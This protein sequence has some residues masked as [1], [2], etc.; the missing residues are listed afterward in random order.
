MADDEVTPLTTTTTNYGWVKPD[1][2]ASD[3]AWGGLL[4]T[5][6]DGIDSTV[7]S[8]S[9]VANAAYPASNP[10][11]YQT[12]AQVTAAVPVASSTTPLVNGTAAVGT[13]TTWARADHVHPTDTS[14]WLGDNRIINGDMR[15][16]QRNNGASGTAN[17]VYTA[18]RWFYSSNV[19]SKGTWTRT[20]AVSTSAIAQAGFPYYLN[21]VSS[22]AYTAATTE[23]FAFH[24]RIEADM[25][26]DFAW[27]TANAQPVTL[28]FW[29]VSNLTGTFGGAITLPAARAY[30]FTFS[31][32]V[33][34]TWTKITMIIPGDTSGAWALTGNA[35]GVRLCFDLGTGATYRAAAGAWV[36]GNFL[37]ATGSVSVVATNGANLAITGVKLE[38]GSVATPYNRQSLAKSTADCQRYYQVNG[39]LYGFAATATAI[40]VLWPFQV[41]M[42]AA[43]T[44]ALLTSTI[45]GE[46]PPLAAAKPGSGSTV[47]ASHAS[48]SATAMDFTVTG[49]TGLTVNAP[50][51][52]T[53]GQI[54][55]SA[56]L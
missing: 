22:S 10:S 13:G 19:A 48:N 3:D 37:T 55:A 41:Q 9:T 2:G 24:Q 20:T 40:S 14:G 51:S 33:A 27:G 52:I 53:A 8:V 50:A 42:R 15:I 38:T 49:F 31:L 4:N 39:Y 16:D 32:P 34:S 28:S 43:A 45:G 12:A 56:E 23:L 6:L 5:D 29:A 44:L 36:S 11:G 54:S 35:E 17:N 7:K 46:S 25:V 1:V 26:S 21:F 47:S 18:D 30:P